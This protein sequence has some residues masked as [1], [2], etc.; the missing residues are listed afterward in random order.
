[1]E[2][3]VANDFLKMLETRDRLPEI[4]EWVGN[5]RKTRRTVRI[6]EQ[7]QRR[8]PRGMGN[9]CVFSL[10]QFLDCFLSGTEDRLLLP[11]WI[12]T[13]YNLKRLRECHQLSLFEVWLMIVEYSMSDADS[14]ALTPRSPLDGDENVTLTEEQIQHVCIGLVIDC[15]E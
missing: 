3:R 12:N 11:C 6:I 4:H 10:I 9:S 5:G 2:N 8:E 15:R 13:V 7:T 14:P 1:M